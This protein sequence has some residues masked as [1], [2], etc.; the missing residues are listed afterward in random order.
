LQQRPHVAAQIL[1]RGKAGAVKISNSAGSA[2][3]RR[4]SSGHI[5][6]N[7]NIFYLYGRTNSDVAW[8]VRSGWRDCGAWLRRARRRRRRACWR[9]GRKRAPRSSGPARRRTR[10]AGR[11]RQ[12]RQVP[13][14][15]EVTE[16]PALHPDRHPVRPPL[17]VTRHEAEPRA[18]VVHDDLG[19]DH[20]FVAG[21]DDRRRAPREES[22]IVLG[23]L[24]E[25]EHPLGGEG[26]ESRLANFHCRRVR[27]TRETCARG[28]CCSRYTSPGRPG[29]SG[30]SPAPLPSAW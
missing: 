28:P 7:V 16:R 24:D 25:V 30:A 23:G 20:R 8:C 6:Y 27:I 29:P 9:C 13:L 22:R 21:Q 5:P 19:G 4:R 2:Q 18:V 10:T 17:R 14:T 11:R 15:L 26:D 12:R 1:E 3:G